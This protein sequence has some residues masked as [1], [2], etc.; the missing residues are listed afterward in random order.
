MKNERKVEIMSRV[1]VCHCAHFGED[2]VVASVDV[3]SR[4][5]YNALEY[6][7]ERTNNIFGSWSKPSQF[8]FNDEII[9]NKDFSEDVT[10]IAPLPVVDGI[11][12]GLRSTSIG[13]KMIFQGKIYEVDVIGFKERSLM[14]FNELNV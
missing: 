8:M 6:A 10:V 13:D 7:F 14:R 5:G 3:G 11:E 1:T 4:E 12:Y 2:T 9:I